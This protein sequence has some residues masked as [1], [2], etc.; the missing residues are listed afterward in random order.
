MQSLEIGDFPFERS[1]YSHCNYSWVNAFCFV[2]LTDEG[3]R[4]TMCAAKIIS[5]QREYNLCTAQYVHVCISQAPSERA[6]NRFSSIG[7]GKIILSFDDSHVVCALSQWGNRAS[8][9]R[10]QYCQNQV[11][12]LN[13]PEGQHFQH[14]Y[15]YQSARFFQLEAIH[16]TLYTV[17]TLLCKLAQQQNISNRQYTVTCSRNFPI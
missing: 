3:L 10:R 17:A 2:A 5:R 9:K 7:I 8:A 4:E 15:G 6:R 13:M 12:D 1:L 11:I 14:E 16:D